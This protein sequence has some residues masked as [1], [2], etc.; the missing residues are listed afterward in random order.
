M[1]YLFN[2]DNTKLLI[3]EKNGKIK[4]QFEIDENILI[5]HEF[6]LMLTCKKGHL[7]ITQLLVSAGANVNVSRATDG[8]TAL[9][10]VSQ[11]GHLEI[12][13]LLVSAGANVNSSRTTDGMT[14]LMWASRE[15]HLK[16]AEFLVTAGANVNASRTSDGQTALMWA[17]QKGYL[18][19][20][21]LLINAGANVNYTRTSNGMTALMWASHKGHLE[22]FKFLV[23]KGAKINAYTEYFFGMTVLKYAKEP[24]KDSIINENRLKIVKFIE[25]QEKRKATETLYDFIK[26]KYL[27]F[28]F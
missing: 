5:D 17:S 2:K 4:F 14:A 12:A 22:I 1:L 10:W 11:K 8:M 24:S 21:Q 27:Y 16:I 28:L 20:T 9:M 3:D 26:E 15:G 7:G 19:I 13:Q 6:D 25:D 23:E 18:E